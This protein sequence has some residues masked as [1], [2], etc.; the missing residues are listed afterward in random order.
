MENNKNYNR[1]NEY[2]EKV[3]QQVEDLIEEIK[4]DEGA[5]AASDFTQGVLDGL[6]LFDSL[7]VYDTKEST[8]RRHH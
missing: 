5:T 3:R 2:M 8:S 1:G 4:M 7:E 6:K